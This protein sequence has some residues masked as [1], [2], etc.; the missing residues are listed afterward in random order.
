MLI[1]KNYPE[2]IIS[3]SNENVYTPSDDTYLIID[4][5]KANID[6]QYF[7]GIRLEKIQKVL[8]LGTG[9]GI[10]ALFLQL[11]KNILP[12]FNPKIYAAD[13][14]EEAIKCAKNNEQNNKVEGEI[15]FI[16]SNLFDSFPKSLEKSFNVIIF[17]PPYLPSI[18]SDNKLIRDFK[19]EASWDGGKRGIEIFT[20][21]IKQVKNFIATKKPSYIYYISSDKAAL[22]ELNKVINNEGFSNTILNKKH[23]FFENIFLNR[24]E[25][26]DG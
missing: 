8:D 5:F 7:D 6:D 14:L 20:R 16:Q 24:L 2:P 17:N 1:I 22:N 13:I 19:K 18:K 3:N 4:Y 23:L 10:I 15:N 9:T 11:I 25:N 12:K 21:F 26:I